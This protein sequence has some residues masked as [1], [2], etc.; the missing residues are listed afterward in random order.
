MADNPTEEDRQ[1]YKTALRSSNG[2]KLQIGRVSKTIEDCITNKKIEDRDLV[3]TSLKLFE[4]QISEIETILDNE[5]GN[6]A[7]PH[8]FLIE[9]TNFVV[10]NA[11][12]ATKV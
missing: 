9:L 2:H 10:E 11:T 8:D 12:M 3:E 4:T 7:C 1:A 5:A 6:P